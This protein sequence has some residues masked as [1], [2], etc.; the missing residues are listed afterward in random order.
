MTYRRLSG[1][2]A[3]LVVLG[4]TCFYWGEDQVKGIHKDWNSLPSQALLYVP[5]VIHIV[6]TNM[7]ANVYRNAAQSLTEYGELEDLTV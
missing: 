6:Y 2:A 4:M 1:S 7:L 3:G 5:S